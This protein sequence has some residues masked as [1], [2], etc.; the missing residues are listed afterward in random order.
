MRDETQINGPI[1]MGGHGRRSC[2]EL[3]GATVLSGGQGS[4]DGSDRDAAFLARTQVA[5][6][7]GLTFVKA[8]VWAARPDRQRDAVDRSGDQRDSETGR[9]KRPRHEDMAG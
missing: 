1:R 7:V 6:D 4:C 3:T 8:L 5:A 9:M 2:R